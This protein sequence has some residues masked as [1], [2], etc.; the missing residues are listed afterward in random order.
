MVTSE[1]QLSSIS[2]NVQKSFE[3][4][5]FETKIYKVLN[6]KKYLKLGVVMLLWGKTLTNI[7]TQ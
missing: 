7:S 4:G 2:K 3:P 6:T 5:T 1:A